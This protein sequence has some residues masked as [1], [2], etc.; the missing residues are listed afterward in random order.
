[1]ADER[2]RILVEPIISSADA[3]AFANTLGNSLTQTARSWRDEMK[4]MTAEG[5]SAGM[6]VAL[7]SG[8]SGQ[9]LK[10]FMQ[11]NV[12]DVYGKFMKELRAGNLAEAQKYSRI[13]DKQTRRFKSEADAIANAFE[14]MGERQAR[15][16][17]QRARGFQQSAEGIDAGLRGGVRGVGGL[18]RGAVNRLR[19]YGLEKQGLAEEQMA[20]AREGGRAAPKGAVRMAKIGKSMAGA[21]KALGA[22][23][24][25]LAVVVLLVKAFIDLDNKMKE[26]RKTVVDTTGAMEFGFGA[27][28]TEARRVTAELDRMRDEFNAVGAEAE[29][30][31]ATTKQMLEVTAAISGAGRNIKFLREEV[32]RAG[33][34][35]RSYVDVT[36]IAI[37]YSRM[38]GE[39][40]GETGGRIGKIA[41]ETG[42]DIAT[43]GDAFAMMTR[44]AEMAGFQTKRFFST[45]TEATSGLLYYNV[46]LQ[47]SAK[48]LGEL[49]QTLGETMG[50]KIFRDVVQ[51]GAKTTEDALKQ[52]YLSGQQRTRNILGAAAAHQVEALYKDLGDK[53]QQALAD[54]GIE[55]AKEFADAM[56]DPEQRE[57]IKE[58]LRGVDMEEFATMIRP[59]GQLVD[60]QRGTVGEVARALKVLPP[61]AK[62]AMLARP[63]GE[64]F[65]GRTF[66]QLV[67]TKDVGVQAALEN[68]LRELGFAMTPEAMNAM[69]DQME[70][71]RNEYEAAKKAGEKPGSFED[72]II[73]HMTDDLAE[74]LTT[75]RDEQ[76]ET[77][78]Q[79]QKDVRDI[80]DILEEHILAVLKSIH[81]VVTDILGAITIGRD[82]G[83]TQKERAAAA[84]RQHRRE[85]E[86][87]EQKRTRAERRAETAETPEERRRAAGEATR[88]E[89]A[90]T[91]EE[92]KATRAEAV[93]AEVRAAEEEAAGRGEEEISIG[94]A[95]AARARGHLT[96][97][98]VTELAGDTKVREMASI[99]ENY[100]RKKGGMSRAGYGNAVM[101]VLQDMEGGPLAELADLGVPVQTAVD[102]ARAMADS[103]DWGF[104]EGAQKGDYFF[105][106]LLEQLSKEISRT[107]AATAARADIQ[108]VGDLLLGPKG[109]GSLIFPPGG[110]KPLMTSP[111]DTVMATRPG[112][113]LSGAMGGSKAPVEINIYGGDQKKVYDT[114]MRVLK[115]TGHA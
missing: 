101:A 103:K 85:Q 100:A 37:T 92:T 24:A 36:N 22:I 88:A 4:K 40:M 8:K 44:E 70:A 89:A 21:A 32:D 115:A 91:Q 31:Y 60:A 95:G 34:S 46:R 17:E 23:G 110:A 59:L 7:A 41:M 90:A 55:G 81:G 61:A 105:D 71:L 74:D 38:L 33:N 13:L 111:D 14:K 35:V 79:I 56:G 113:P 26:L 19:Q 52:Y 42:M 5:H 50:T 51:G 49:S 72:Y 69:A 1:M 80:S 12:A 62:F 108:K 45:V 3:R 27:G 11:S 28:Q 39:S 2:T 63:G 10:S 65:G 57:K 94:E 18:G 73:N 9:A 67:E 64:V 98:G 47:D 29:G 87:Q 15:T 30:M 109:A 86:K 48:L 58:S 75:V 54:I 104:F 83:A 20:A 97:S 106:Q 107:S 66:E 16:F 25:A 77:A 112:G 82:E 6:K 96:A 93:A 78:K 114:V 102:V 53:G 76:M 84:A 68:V 43:I 99:L